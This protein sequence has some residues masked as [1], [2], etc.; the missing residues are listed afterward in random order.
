MGWGL[1]DVTVRGS[2]LLL[3]GA[4]LLFLL[5]G[6]G[7]GLLISAVAQTQQVAFFLSVFSSLLPTFLLSGFVFPLKSMPW[8]LQGIGAILP[9]KYFLIIVRSII[10]KDV[11][12]WPLWPEFLALGLFTL[13]TVTISSIRL[14]RDLSS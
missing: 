11:G 13:A 10:L 12:F 1:F 8:L 9:T 4:I 3:Y 2:L 7:Q 5:A 14:H 6:L